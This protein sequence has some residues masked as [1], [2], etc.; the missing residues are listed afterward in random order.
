MFRRPLPK[1]AAEL[2][3]DPKLLL[4]RSRG[5]FAIIIVM[6]NLTQPFDQNL[7]TR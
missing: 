3:A 7:P 5:T 1:T 6:R 2:A 4:H